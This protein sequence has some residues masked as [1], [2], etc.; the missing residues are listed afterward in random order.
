MTVEPNADYDRGYAAALDEVES[1]IRR[2]ASGAADVRLVA[3]HDGKPGCP[4]TVWD[5]PYSMRCSLGTAVGRC[6]YHGAFDTHETTVNP[7]GEGQ[8]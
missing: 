7:P 4:V 5:G 8:S 1:R 3:D 2:Q 6:A